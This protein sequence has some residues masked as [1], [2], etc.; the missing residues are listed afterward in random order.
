M[1]TTT[2]PITLPSNLRISGS[3]NILNGQIEEEWKW[4]KKN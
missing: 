1:M 4:I 3:A 2:Y